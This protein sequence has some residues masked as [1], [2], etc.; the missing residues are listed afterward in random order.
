MWLNILHWCPVRWGL[1]CLCCVKEE[2]QV[3]A[4]FQIDLSGCL[5]LVF[6]PPPLCWRVILAL[7]WVSGLSLSVSREKSRFEATGC[8]VQHFLCDLGPRATAASAGTGPLHNIAMLCVGHRPERKPLSLCQHDWSWTGRIM[9]P[10]S[11]LSTVMLNQWKKYMQAF[12]LKLTWQEV[13]SWGRWQGPQSLRRMALF[14][15]MH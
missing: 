3:P 10:G 15:L 1:H 14:L 7:L 12:Q 4:E 9:V 5:G 8:R 11:N 2:S 6:P 13:D